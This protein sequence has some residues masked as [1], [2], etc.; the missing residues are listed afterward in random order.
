MVGP[1]SGMGP[2]RPPATRR[3]CPGSPA[4]V[5]R[6]RAMLM[7]ESEPGRSARSPRDAIFVAFDDRYFPFARACLNSLRLNY[8]GHPPL[9]VAYRGSRSEVYGFLDTLGPW[10]DAMPRLG[11]LP[12][13]APP[14]GPVG[15]DIVYQRL[16]LWSDRFDDFGN[17]LHLDVDTLVLGSLDPLIRK[18]D[19]FAVSN[20]EPTA[21]GRIFGTTDPGDRDLGRILCGDGLDFPGGMDHMVNAGVFL[22]PRRY[23]SGSRFEEIVGITNRYRA[24]LAYADQS[25]IS[26]W[27]LLN[28]IEAST[29]YAF[30]YQTPFLTDPTVRVAFADVRILHFSSP[31]KP[32][33]PAFD[34]WARVGGNGDALSTLFRGF[35]DMPVT[36]EPG[37]GVSDTRILRNMEW[38]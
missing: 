4:P 38:R 32:G 7:N 13:D 19:F 18:A 37:P 12:L 10:T 36:S 33:T 28:R 8:A 6:E 9:L 15:N 35:R 25:A 22:I 27:C 30:N 1:E 24:F 5:D 2:E 16:W 17:I 34:Q 14:A 23:R 3:R 21:G 31:R 29:D 11:D 26:L 20:H